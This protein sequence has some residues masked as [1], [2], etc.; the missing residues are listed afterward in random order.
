MSGPGH[1]RHITQAE[2]RGFQNEPGPGGKGKLR[3]YLSPFSF[4]SVKAGADLPGWATALTGL[5]LKGREI[6]DAKDLV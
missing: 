2:L 4:S 5:A 3:V 1:A 6:M